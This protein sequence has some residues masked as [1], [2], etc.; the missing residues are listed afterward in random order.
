LRTRI[1]SQLAQFGPQPELSELKAPQRQ[2]FETLCAKQQALTVACDPK[3]QIE[4]YNE[5]FKSPDRWGNTFVR[6]GDI[7]N[8]PGVGIEGEKLRSLIW[9]A[10]LGRDVREF[11]RFQEIFCRPE[12]YVVPRFL[13]AGTTEHRSK[14]ALGQASPEHLFRFDA[15]VRTAC[16]SVLG[17]LVSPDRISNSL[18]EHLGLYDPGAL[19]G[20]PFARLIAKAKLPVLTTVKLIWDASLAFRGSGRIRVIAAPSERVRGLYKSANVS[21]PEASIGKVLI[22]RELPGGK[23]G[24]WIR[25]GVQYFSDPHGSLR[26]AQH[27]DTQYQSEV[28]A[29]AG[30]ETNLRTLAQRIDKNWGDANA[31]LKEHLLYE[32]KSAIA[33]AVQHL[34]K[35]QDAQKRRAKELLGAA[36]SFRDSRDRLNPSA[37][38]TRVANAVRN[39]GIR[40]QGTQMRGRYIHQDGAQFF[41]EVQRA[42][43]AIQL[44][45]EKISHFVAPTLHGLVLFK[46]EFPEKKRAAQ[47][48]LALA[49]FGINPSQYG[50]STRAPYALLAAKLQEQYDALEVG[51]LRGQREMAYK[52][53]VKMF[54]VVKYHAVYESLEQIKEDLPQFEKRL[55]G[56]TKNNAASVVADLIDRV[57]YMR[58][59]M[60]EHQVL[61]QYR[62]P[63]DQSREYVALRQKLQQI[64]RGLERYRLSESPE[65]VKK[66]LGRFKKYMNENPVLDVL[67]P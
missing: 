4:L 38:L 7:S 3:A 8:V 56:G 17:T 27:I 6:L 9:N 1:E 67:K 52:A 63:A 19:K 62:L 64:E 10:L 50:I 29:L 58:I 36:A 34:G 2:K 26:R 51:M 14:K 45:G 61:P 66:M 54:L 49:R 5:A 20:D 42:R 37:V 43:A 28:R 33:E 13:V 46:P 57:T 55:E 24:S 22:S 40:V 41:E 25:R 53:L 59:L 15:V 30:I 32:A 21:V 23:E 31:D 44:L 39:L 18:C 65:E 47:T 11:K 48:K 60:A 16:V 35:P 12:D